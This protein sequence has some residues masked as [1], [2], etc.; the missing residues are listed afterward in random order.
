MGSCCTTRP[1]TSADGNSA[2]VEQMR[3]D[4]LIVMGTPF[5]VDHLA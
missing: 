3:I 1:I 5:Q 4:G 2:K